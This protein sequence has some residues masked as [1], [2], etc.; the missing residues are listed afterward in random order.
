M[1]LIDNIP[2]IRRV[3]RHG[4]SWWKHSPYLRFFFLLLLGRE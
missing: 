2:S 4:D 3:V 1:Y